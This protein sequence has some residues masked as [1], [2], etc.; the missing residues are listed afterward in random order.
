MDHWR[1][2]LKNFNNMSMG[3]HK[4]RKF[5]ENA[6][7]AIRKNSLFLIG[8][9]DILTYYPESLEI[10]DKLEMNYIII[11]GAGHAANHEKPGEVNQMIIRF[12]EG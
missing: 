9:S 12:L 8:D 1:L 2:L 11:E 5:Q 7:E 4:I 10:L 3:F 6:F